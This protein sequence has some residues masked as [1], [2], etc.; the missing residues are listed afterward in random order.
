M[1]SEQAITSIIVGFFGLCTTVAT[2]VSAYYMAKMKQSTDRTEGVMGEVHTAVNSNH[3]ASVAEGKELRS[4]IETLKNEITD[5]K[6]NQATAAERQ[7]PTAP[8]GSA[9]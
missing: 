3:Q 5:L 6:V 4:V 7:T 2:L 1:F 8:D 9:K